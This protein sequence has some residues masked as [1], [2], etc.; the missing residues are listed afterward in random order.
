M[1]RQQRDDVMELNGKV[2]EALPDAMFRV[3]VRVND[4]AAPFQV[5]AYLAG[6]MRQH[7]IRV[8]PGDTVTVAVS[9]YDLTKGRIT[10]RERGGMPPSNPPS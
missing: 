2:L 1:A 4:D 10:F 8:L 6:K 7:R 3:E 5:L 9:T